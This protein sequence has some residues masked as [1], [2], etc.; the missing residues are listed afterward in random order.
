MKHWMTAFLLG[1]CV[2]GSLALTAA[3]PVLAQRAGAKVA[4]CKDHFGQ[5]L[6][7]AESKATL[8]AWE[9]FSHTTSWSVVPTRHIGERLRC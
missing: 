2:F 9:I 1:C 4:A 6:P 3:V 8:Q 5:A 7:M